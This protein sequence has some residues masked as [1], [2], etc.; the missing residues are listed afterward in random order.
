M[1]RG[2]D[3][4]GQQFEFPLIPW[5]VPAGIVS[6]YQHDW[7]LATPNG[8]PS[9]AH[10]ERY[11]V[12]DVWRNAFSLYMDPRYAVVTRE[13]SSSAMADRPCDCLRPKSSLSR[14]QHCQ[15]FSAGRHA[16]VIRQT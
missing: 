16:V 1:R 15:W 12:H 9:R 5:L 4:G 3:N 7:P 14:C 6:C 11:G 10:Y 8:E 2:S 13:T